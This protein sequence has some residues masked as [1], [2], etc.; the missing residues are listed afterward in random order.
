[1]TSMLQSIRRGHVHRAVDAP[2]WDEFGGPCG[3]RTRDLRI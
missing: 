2:D 3:D 1:M